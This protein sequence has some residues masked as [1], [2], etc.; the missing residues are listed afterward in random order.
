MVSLEKQT[1][2][3]LP[4]NTPYNKGQSFRWQGTF[5]E[6]IELF[7]K[8]PLFSN[9]QDLFQ[10]F[11]ITDS[12]MSIMKKWNLEDLSKSA[13]FFYLENQIS[14]RSKNSE[15]VLNKYDW[16]IIAQL[17]INSKIS[18]HILV[19]IKE[20]SLKEGSSEEIIRSGSLFAMK[21]LVFIK[22]D[23]SN[24][25]GLKNLLAF[26]KV[27]LI[28]I[29]SLV[30]E[31]FQKQSFLP[32]INFL[33]KFQNG[34]DKDLLLTEIL[35]F[36]K[37]NKKQQNIQNVEEKSKSLSF[38]LFEEMRFE[39]ESVNIFDIFD[40]SEYVKFKAPEMM[41]FLF[42]Q[43]LLITLGTGNENESLKLLRLFEKYWHFSKNQIFIFKDNSFYLLKEFSELNKSFILAGISQIGNLFRIINLFK[44]DPKFLK[45]KLKEIEKK[46][47]I[48]GILLFSALG[49]QFVI[50]Q[51]GLS[52]RRSETD[53][54]KRPY[55][56]PFASMISNTSS[57]N[58]S[59][60]PREN[61]SLIRSAVEHPRGNVFVVMQS[62]PGHSLRRRTVRGRPPMGPSNMIRGLPPQALIGNVAPDAQ[63]D[64]APDA[65]AAQQNVA[66]A[67]EQTVVQQL[68]DL[69]SNDSPNCAVSVNEATVNGR[70]VV[71]ILCTTGLYGNLDPIKTDFM[72]SDL[73]HIQ[74]VPMDGEHIITAPIRGSVGV[75]DENGA[76]YYMIRSLHK[77]HTGHMDSSL[78]KTC[79]YS[80]G[81]M[82]G[83]L[84]DYFEIKKTRYLDVFD[85]MFCP[86]PEKEYL[87]NGQRGVDILTEHGITVEG[88]KSAA[89]T[90]FDFE[91]NRLDQMAIP[92]DK[93]LA[94]SHV[95]GIQ[96][97]IVKDCGTFKE[98]LTLNN[99][100]TKRPDSVR[101]ALKLGCQ[102][103]I[104]AQKHYYAVAANFTPKSIEALTAFDVYTEGLQSFNTVFNYYKTAAGP[105]CEELAKY[106]EEIN[107]VEIN[108]EPMYPYS[109][110]DAE[111]C[112]RND[113]NFNTPKKGIKT[114]FGR[115]YKLIK[116]D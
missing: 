58:F 87:V 88:M 16:S 106:L 3:R 24:G 38:A 67:T 78:P 99:Y 18:D 53:N 15:I 81:T 72:A 27:D 107:K 35:Q 4:V 47:V 116:E 29:Q 7:E 74:V 80:S 33:E 61:E 60:S 85:K 65:L 21:D 94:W 14:E 79:T 114:I 56:H 51:F 63:Q 23:I 115:V 50:N 71:N 68:K 11:P 104:K 102:N 110:A 75:S 6:A 111:H 89:A 84:I 49:L 90:C 43:E 45:K 55:S 28:S 76:A 54:L 19:F 92:N 32:I 48:L 100:P 22:E 113:F 97:K 20:I 109:L 95:Y 98:N 83:T 73:A 46:D 103:F 91:I 82:A 52:T 64:V 69:L 34:L 41:M 36:V 57:M 112:A 2:Y 86:N 93:L 30:N 13:L 44:G 17:L 37:K 96:N 10:V 25:D 9:S 70:V 31:A 5:L 42:Y 77:A 105:L 101:N 1:N 39:L 26:L 12:S 66:P 62:N 8:L 59:Q 40:S 108:Q